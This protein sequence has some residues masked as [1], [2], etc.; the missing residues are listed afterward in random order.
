MGDPPRH[1]RRKVAPGLAE[2]HDDAAGH[3]FAAVVARAL[4]DGDRAG[5]AHRKALAGDAAEVAFARDRAV[6]HGVA[7]DDALLRHD[8]AIARRLDDELAA[9]EA[10]SDI[11][12]GF[13]FEVEGDTLRKPGAER[14][15]RGALEAD[16]DG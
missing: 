8:A 16:G 11:V 15:S 6:Q 7:D 10:L 9:G 13:A 2:H 5:V 1:A 12:V 3:V 4:D 14:L